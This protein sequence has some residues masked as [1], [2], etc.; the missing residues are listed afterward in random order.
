MR[1]NLNVIILLVVAALVA[2]SLYYIIPPGETTSLGLDLQGG[3][4]VVYEARTN[5]GEVPTP[6][7]MEQ[8]LSIIDRR[9]NGLGVSE[10]T[11][12]QQGADQVSIQLPGV[13]DPQQ[14]LSLSLIHI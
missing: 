10:S 9:V 11:V 12:Q 7:Q 3:L 6:A 5:T 13:T 2:A 14:A 1:K 4:E 8:T